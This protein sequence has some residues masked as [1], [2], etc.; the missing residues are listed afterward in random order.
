MCIFCTPWVEKKQYRNGMPWI[1]NDCWL[2]LLCSHLCRKR[3]ILMLMYYTNEAAKYNHTAS[4]WKT[5][6]KRKTTVRRLLKLYSWRNNSSS[7]SST[8]PRRLCSVMHNR[9]TGVRNT[10]IFA[11]YNTYTKS[12]KNRRSKYRRYTYTSEPHYTFCISYYPM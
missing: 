9:E 11:L 2:V 12:T 7:K 1:L 3:L 6:T 8:N 4:G 5:H 10:S